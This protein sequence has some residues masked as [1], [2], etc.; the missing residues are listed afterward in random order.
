MLS[1]KLGH[2]L[3]E[4]RVKEIF[5]KIKQQ[6]NDP[7][8]TELDYEEFLEAFNGLGDLVDGDAVEKVVLHGPHDGGLDFN[9]NRVVG[10]LLE[11][12]DDA[13]APVETSLGGCVEVG[14]ELGKGG[15]FAELG[16]KLDVE[17][18]FEKTI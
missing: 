12:L 2:P 13:G 16:E 14:L 11:H 18:K 17:I 5:S 3:T 4:H 1:K 15:E 7:G 10:A 8:S 9:G 6:S